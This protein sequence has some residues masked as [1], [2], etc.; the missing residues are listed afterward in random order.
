MQLR[1]IAPREGTETKNNIL[2]NTSLFIKKYSS[3][4]GDGNTLT[5][6]QPLPC[7]I[8]KYS[9]PRGDGNCEIPNLFARS[10]CVLRNIAPREGTE[11]WEVVLEKYLCIIKKY[12]SPRGDGNFSEIIFCQCTPPLLRNIAPREGTETSTETLLMVVSFFY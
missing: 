12:S 8:K 5:G 2:S 11:T 6:S 7:H 1:N 3:P 10:L 9:S 4:R